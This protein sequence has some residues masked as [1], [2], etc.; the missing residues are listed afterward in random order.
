LLT[1]RGS[2]SQWHTQTRTGKSALLNQLG[3]VEP[4]VEM[5]PV[6]AAPLGIAPDS[7]VVVRSRRGEMVARAFLTHT[8]KP[9][10]LFVPMHFARTN[11]LTFGAFDPKSRQPA[12]KACAVTVAPFEDKR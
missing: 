3:A 11:Q 2:S 6:D 4:Y 10:Q 12:Y 1:G 5:S 9:G 8:V 7:R